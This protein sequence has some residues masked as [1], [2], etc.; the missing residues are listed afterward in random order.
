MSADP[1]K[2][3]PWFDFYPERFIAGTAIMELSERGAY[4]TL[5]CHQWLA[6]SLPDDPRILARLVGG[7]VAPAVLEKFPVCD[8]GKRR[9]AKL[10]SVRGDQV[11]RMHKNSERAKKAASARWSPDAS[12]NAQAMLQASNKHA[13]SIAQ[14]MPKSCLPQPSTLNP[15]PNTQH[16]Q[17][18]DIVSASPPHPNPEKAK[19]QKFQK[20]T[21]DEWVS[22]A[23]TMPEPL[24]ENQA[25]GAWDYYEANGWKVGRNPMVNWQATLR[26]WSR[27]QKEHPTASSQTSSTNDPRHQPIIDGLKEPYE[28]I[29]DRPFN[30]N[31][32][33][34]QSALA[35]FLEKNP[36]ISADRFL[37]GWEM[38]CEHSGDPY[39]PKIT[40]ALNPV[41]F[42]NNY[43]VV[44]GHIEAACNA[45]DQKR[46]R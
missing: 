22:Y 9:N 23:T 42:C 43:G 31:P 38:V 41:Y 27:R 12:S 35:T 33:S 25:L 46:S 30:L 14:A 1:F 26:A 7:D 34:F 4:I 32:E 24:T 19:R 16:P 29:K 18:S 39:R 45:E 2:S 5:L 13:P 6:G 36:S 8:D 20:P 37:A 44:C 15:Q 28:R 3:A 11:E 17:P 40:E 10:E 21:Q